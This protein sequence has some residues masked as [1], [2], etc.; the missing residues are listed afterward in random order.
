MNQ[1]AHIVSV[2]G[3][4]DSTATLLLALKQFPGEVIPVFADTGNEH[5]VTLDYLDYL[6]VTLGVHIERLKADFSR[7][8]AR[9]REYIA[10]HWLDDGVPAERVERALQ[11]LQPTGNPYLDLC[12]MKGRFPSRRAQFCTQ[13]LKTIP[14]TEFQMSVMD[15]VGCDVWSWQGVRRDES[16]NRRNALG[17]EALG[18]NF[19]VFRPIAGWTGQQTIDYVRS[20]GLKL[21]PL[22]SQGMNRVGCMPC[23]N[24]SKAELAEIARRFPE[25]V[26]RIT[27][28]EKLV[29][30]CSKRAAASFFAAPEDGRADL[31]GRN[32]I[33]YVQWA[34]T[35]FGGR[36]ADPKWEEEAPACSSSYGLCE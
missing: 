10:A 8:I 25:H 12:M 28:W 6:E 20:C 15:L 9:K 23:I 35:K 33:K 18:G 34:K 5:Q 36:E 21:N 30:G 14:L 7:D 17:L 2:S 32:V 1:I 22:Y 26:E 3:G 31:R 27:E 4:K 29:A 19:F 16:A 13:E 24:V 11:L